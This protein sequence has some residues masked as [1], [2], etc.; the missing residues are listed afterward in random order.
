MKIIGFEEHY[1]FPAIYE[2]N[3]NNPVEL[4]YE[5]SRKAGH[6][7][8]AGIY[9][10][11]E[12]RI[13][14]MDAAGL[15]V[16][17][18]SHTVPGPETLEPS[19]AVE[20][21]RQAN[22]AVAKAV[23]KYR[24]RFLGFATLPMRDPAAAALELERTVRDSGFVGALINGHINGRYLDDKF[25]WPVFECAETLGVPI[26]LHPT[27]PPQPVVDAYYGGFDPIVSAAL[28]RAGLGWH[29]E[30]GIHCMRLIL[31][32]VFDRFPG[33]QIIVGHHFE[34]LSWMAWRTDYSSAL[35]EKSGLKRTIKEYLRENFYG[36][37]LA[38]EFANQ[39]PGAIDSSWS[40]S[41]NAYL[42]MANLIGIDRIVFT[43]DYPY[44][45]TKAAR[46][47]F[48]QMPINPADKEKIAHLNAERLLRL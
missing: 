40:L 33:L 7:T 15:D 25:F 28:S 1:K 17:I 31:G 24:D 26:Y 42:A 10:L 30:T 5:L 43:S 38:G 13:A 8:D 18:L 48:D 27:V 29:I 16:Q 6:L 4:L 35:N 22:N 3:K 20:L 9:D 23:S 45:N 14:A 21:A 46:Q 36:G 37:I 12:G 11:G 2:A 39:A 34:A 44:G 47:F 19:L 32:G 41:Y